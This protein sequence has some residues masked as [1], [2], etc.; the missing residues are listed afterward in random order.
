MELFLGCLGLH[1]GAR[2]A[3]AAQGEGFLRLGS[4]LDSWNKSEVRKLIGGEA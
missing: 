2:E 4:N 1:P 3:V